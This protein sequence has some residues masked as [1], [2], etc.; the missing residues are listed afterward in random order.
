MKYNVKVVLR[1]DFVKETP[2]GLEVGIRAVPEKGKANM[3]LVRALAKHFNVPQS[4]VC[5]V[6]GATSRRK[7]VE[8][9]DAFISGL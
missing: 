6:S 4:A 7:V 2:E 8:I 3:E 1:G 9:D 5:I